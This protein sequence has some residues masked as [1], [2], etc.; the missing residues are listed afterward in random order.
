VAASR[1]PMA[2]ALDW[3]RTHN[4]PAGFHGARGQ[5]HILHESGRFSSCEVQLGGL[6]GTEGSHH[7]PHAV[8]LV[9]VDRVAHASIELHSHFPTEE[10]QDL[11]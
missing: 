1:G 5:G 2:I 8:Q 6:G 3:A 7:G 11:P 4:E 10:L 9:L